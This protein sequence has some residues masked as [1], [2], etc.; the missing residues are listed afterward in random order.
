[1]NK[2][3]RWIDILLCA[4]LF[5]LPFLHVNVG[6]GIADQGYNL[7]NFES[8]PNMNQTW[9]IATLVAN[10]VGK[11]FTVLPFGHTMV[12]M[13]IY[14]TLLLSTVSVIIYFILK[15]V[16]CR[17]GVFIGLLIAVCFSWAPKVTLYQYLSY[18]LFCASAVLLVQ[19]LQNNKKKLLFGAGV[20]LGINLFV[21]FPNILQIALILIV[22]IHEIFAKRKVK[23]AL[24]DIASCIAGYVIVV[25]P[26]IGAVEI[27]MGKGTYIGMVKSLFAMTDEAASYS[28][29]SMLT[30][31]YSSYV[32]NLKWMI[33][34]IFL[35]VIGI[36]IYGFLHKKIA[37]AIFYVF[38][39]LGFAFILRIRWYYGILNI[40][41]TTYQSVYV[42]GVCFLFLAII[43]LGL[44]LFCSQITWE[45]KLYSMVALVIIFISPLG[46]N[47]ALYSNFNN[48]Y[49]VAPILIG[50]L[51]TLWE[52]FEKQNATKKIWY[53]SYN[54]FIV[55]AILLTM[56]VAVQTFLFHS[57]FVF[58]DEGIN[59]SPKVSVTDNHVLVGMKTTETNAKMLEELDE[60]IKG[61]HGDNTQYIIWGH[62]PLLYYALDIECAIGH[63]WPALDSYSYEEFEEDMK[64]MTEN[65]II[66][67]EAQYYGDLLIEDNERA[68]KVSLVAN[69]MQQENYVEVFRNQ[70]YVICIAEG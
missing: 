28:P 2:K 47:N 13:N 43:V 30:A 4:I 52:K 42:W 7:Q 23:D 65:P 48:L 1:M 16:Y 45:Q 21:R 17:Y 24:L 5:V 59:G 70:Y 63:I 38:L 20:L 51:A 69:Y 55:V 14:C 66:I 9:M 44:S 10:V 36:I 35:A 15:K 18:Y 32:E 27:G 37:K 67:Y 68:G 33:G 61:N 25:A 22:I 31:M 6:I 11:I 39:C 26:I 3:G 19:G 49:L 60:Y 29:F 34:F 54:P 64:K 62:S 12:G 41:Y 53:L 8:F 57:F 40:N 56:V 50:A 46:S 58:G